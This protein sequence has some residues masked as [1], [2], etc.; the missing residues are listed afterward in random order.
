MSCTNRTCWFYVNLQH[1]P[2]IWM[3]HIYHTQIGYDI[4]IYI[5]YSLYLTSIVCCLLAWRNIIDTYNLMINFLLNEMSINVHM[6]C[7][8]MM[9]WILHNTYS[10]LI[11]TKYP[12]SVCHTLISSRDYPFVGM[13]PSFDH[14]E[15]LGTHR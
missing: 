4:L 10:N 15:V 13:R 11:I 2:S 14:F 1:S 12:H 7:S 5:P 3:V 8:T 6:L 9:N